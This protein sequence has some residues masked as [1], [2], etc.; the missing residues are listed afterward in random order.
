MKFVVRGIGLYLLFNGVWFGFAL[1]IS[2]GA[3]LRE[4]GPLI[5]VTTIIYCLGGFYT[6]IQLIQSKQRGRVLASCLFVW[7]IL[8][9]MYDARFH[10]SAGH[11]SV[12]SVVVILLINACLLALLQLPGVRRHCDR[13]SGA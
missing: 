2:G 9:T 8:H 1:L 6:G 11:V 3:I 7:K 13:E 4:G 12:P 5:L 10:S